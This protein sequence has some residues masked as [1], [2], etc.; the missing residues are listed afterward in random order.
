MQDFDHCLTFCRVSWYKDG[1]R[2]GNQIDY[3]ESTLTLNNNNDIG[4]YQC[5]AA[6]DINQRKLEVISEDMQAVV[7]G[8]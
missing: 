5:R 8:R 1:E 2:I 4:S 3:N 7:A 6:N